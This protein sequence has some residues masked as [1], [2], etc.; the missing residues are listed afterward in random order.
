MHVWT[1]TQLV[2]LISVHLN[3][4]LNA[5]PGELKISLISRALFNDGSMST[6]T[7]KTYCF[8]NGL[9]PIFTS[10]LEKSRI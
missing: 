6:R 1:Q 4:N 2:A 5:L 10:R 8:I 7:P 3:S 9:N